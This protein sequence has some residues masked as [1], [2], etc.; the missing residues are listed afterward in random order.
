MKTLQEF[1]RFDSNDY[2]S[3]LSKKDLFYFFILLDNYYLEYRKSLEIPNK[4]TFGIEIEAEYIGGEFYEEIKKYFNQGW[5]RKTDQS[6]MD[7]DE[8]ISPVMIDTEE[9]WKQLKGLCDI[10]KDNHEIKDSCGGHIHIGANILGNKK[11]NWLHFLKMWGTYENIIFRF[12]YGEFLNHRKNI[13][14]YA[15]P[16][17]D[18]IHFLLEMNE[19]KKLNTIDTIN[20]FQLTRGDALNF[21]NFKNTQKGYGNTIEIRCPN[22]TLE[23]IIWQN[24]INFFIKFILYC[25]N[26]RYNE[27]IIENRISQ[28]KE[29]GQIKNYD[30]I[31]INQA[32]ELSDMIFYNNLDKVYFLRQYLKSF[33]KI[34][35]QPELKP[36]KT[37]IKKP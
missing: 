17:S 16:I 25:K 24:N 5:K 1:I 26:D 11:E 36:A 32:I 18:E 4:Y 27:D 33:Q 8:Y 28:N 22:G 15:M 20:Y 9:N 3:K 30:Y 31:D 6:L 10:L 7:G 34:K 13:N 12:S 2:L 29:F 35:K 21:D 23:P 14:Y 37:F 19:Y